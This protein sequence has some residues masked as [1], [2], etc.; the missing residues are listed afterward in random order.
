MGNTDSSFTRTNITG[1]SAW[2]INY[3]PSFLWGVITHPYH[4]LNS[5]LAQ[6]PWKSR[7]GWVTSTSHCFM[8]LILHAGW[9]V[10]CYS[11]LLKWFSVRS[12]VAGDCAFFSNICRTV[13]KQI[14]DFKR[15]R[16]WTHFD[17]WC[18]ILI[19]LIDTCNIWKWYMYQLIQKWGYYIIDIRQQDWLPPAFNIWGNTE[20]IGPTNPY[21]I[22]L[23]IQWNLYEVTTT[24]YGLS[25]Q[26]VFHNREMKH[27]FVKTV[28]G[29]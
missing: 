22:Y 24:W 21:Y 27:D 18:N 7:H 16:M 25:G 12:I 17:K 11:E 20:K 1:I 15:G 2:I 23:L 8:C 6:P 10:L 19:E 14:V 3:N 28:T 13:I 4:S 29:K 26:V 9:A 5:S